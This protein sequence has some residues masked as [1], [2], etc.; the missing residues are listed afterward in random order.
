VEEVDQ[1]IGERGTGNGENN[2]YKRSWALPSG[3]A[4][5]HVKK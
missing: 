5:S 1:V 3:R 2:K 4:F